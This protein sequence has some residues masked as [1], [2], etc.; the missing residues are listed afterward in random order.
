MLLQTKIFHFEMAHAIFGYPGD[1]K[2]IHGHSYELHVTVSPVLEEQGYLPAPGFILD[3]K[4][5]KKLVQASVIKTFDHKLVLSQEYLARHPAL[6]S[7][8][9]LVAWEAEPTA[10]N[11]L[12]YIQRTLVANLPATI[13]LVAI[14]LYETTSS[15]ASWVH[16]ASAIPYI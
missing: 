12:I 15:Y 4:E 14:K 10:E 1:C 13:R 6:Q 3:F 7:Q 5:L 16:T 8:E 2:N 11:M 9:N